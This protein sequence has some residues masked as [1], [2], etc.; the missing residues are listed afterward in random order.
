MDGAEGLGGTDGLRVLTAVVAEGAGRIFIVGLAE[1]IEVLGAV[2]VDIFEAV[3]CCLAGHTE[4]AHKI[5]RRKIVLVLKDGQSQG[6]QP[7]CVRFHVREDVVVLVC[8]GC[9]R[10]KKSFFLHV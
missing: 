4:D 3:V 7:F 1:A 8:C 2:F 9:G 10:I 6:A 5:P